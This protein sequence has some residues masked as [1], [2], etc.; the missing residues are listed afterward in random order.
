MLEAASDGPG[1][2]SIARKEPLKM[3]PEV[4][5]GVEELSAHHKECGNPT[6]VVAALGARSA[7]ELV[8]MVVE[9]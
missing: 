2:A 1:V 6:R 8:A 5:G 7:G 9:K 3:P 4:A